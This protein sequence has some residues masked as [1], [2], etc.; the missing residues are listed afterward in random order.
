MPLLIAETDEA[1]CPDGFHVWARGVACQRSNVASIGRLRVWSLARPRVAFG[2]LWPAKY[3]ILKR[4]VRP[5]PAGQAV[6]VGAVKELDGRGVLRRDGQAGRLSFLAV[7]ALIVIIRAAQALIMKDQPTAVTIQSP[8][9]PG[10]PVAAHPRS[11]KTAAAT[12]H[13]SARNR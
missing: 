12:A 13:P 9:P 4:P 8:V 10:P 5:S 6:L 3:H 11:R 2:R 7:I 1:S